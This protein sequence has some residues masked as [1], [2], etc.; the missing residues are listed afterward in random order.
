MGQLDTCPAL[1]GVQSTIHDHPTFPSLYL[2]NLQSSGRD[3]PT[4]SQQMRHCHHYNS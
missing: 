4:I 2:V 1:Q 3:R